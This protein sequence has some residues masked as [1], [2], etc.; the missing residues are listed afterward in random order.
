MLSRA[1]VVI[2]SVWELGMMRDRVFEEKTAK[3]RLSSEF[4]CFFLV[5][6]ELRELGHW[7]KCCGGCLEFRRCAEVFT[8]PH[9]FRTDSEDSPSCPRTV[10]GPNSD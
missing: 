7:Y 9:V 8:L 5:S 4:S 2:K 1:G 6:R 3:F 10:L